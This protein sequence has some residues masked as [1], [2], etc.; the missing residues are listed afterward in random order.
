MHPQIIQKVWSKTKCFHISHGLLDEI[1]SPGVPGFDVN[2][3]CAPTRPLLTGLK[4]FHAVPSLFNKHSEDAC[5]EGLGWAFELSSPSPL[6]ESKS[7]PM[8]TG[9]TSSLCLR[10]PEKISSSSDSSS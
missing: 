6:Q 2:T 10:A 5:L 7:V 4:N 3:L 8:F 1:T 9:D